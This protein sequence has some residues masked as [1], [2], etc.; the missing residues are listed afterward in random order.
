MLSMLSG[1]ASAAREDLTHVLSLDEAGVNHG[2]EEI[3]ALYL[4][5]SEYWTG[6]W[7]DAVMHIDLAVTTGH[8]EQRVYVLSQ[9]YSCASWVWAARGEAVRAQELLRTA[10]QYAIPANAVRGFIGWAI[11]AQARADWAAMLDIVDRMLRTRPADLLLCRVLWKPLQVEALIRNGRPGRAA[12]ALTELAALARTYPS[13]SLALAWLS[14]E[15]A[16]WHGDT[17][18]ALDHY[19]AGLAL[20]ATPDDHVLHRAFL[21]Q[22]YGRLLATT[23]EAD[24]G[25]TWLGRALDRYTALG[26]LPFYDR[27]QA[28]LTAAGSAPETVT[29]DSVL[30]GFSERERDIARLIAQGL[31]NREIGEHLF[32]SSRT[33]EY[34][35]GNIYGKLNLS[36]RR[37]L[38]DH[39]RR[40]SRWAE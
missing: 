5:M 16:R 39:V 37:Q 36:G 20:P 33:V 17:S 21:E 8:C 19:G 35:L 22:G 23:G 15:L 32:I 26:A 4:G 40:L 7:D 25:R 9:A 29:K 18:A 2:I 27:C 14:G 12:T 38:R 11:E 6:A 1:L 24:E 30:A 10:E 34:H 28:D 3:A 31:T 13:L